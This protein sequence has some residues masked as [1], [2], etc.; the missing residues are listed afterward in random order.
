MY[1]ETKDSLFTAL[2]LRW[3]VI[4]CGVIANQMAEALAAEG[5]HIDG[6]ANRTHEKAVAFANK[7]GVARVYDT[8]DDLIAAPDIDVLYLTTPHNTHITYLR[9]ALAA[10]KHVLCE[11]SI[12]LNSAELAEARELASAHGVQLMDAC[13]ILHMPL[14]KELQR[15]ID[16]GDF[17]QVNLIQENFG[18]YKEYDMKNRFFNPELAGGALLDIGVYSL[19]LARLFLKSQPHEA[20]SMMNPA[21]TGT[22]ETEGILLRNAEGQMVVLSL[23]MHSK[24]PKRAMISADKAY[25]EI[26]EYPRAD[27]A[28]IVWTETGVREELRVGNTAQALSYVLADME[29]AVAG[30]EYARAQLG[31][32]ADVMELMTNLRADWNFKY[33]EEL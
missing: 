11:K 7:H 18:S 8:I 10:G 17:G 24:Q 9:K 16:A 26:M 20:L 6:V 30:D 19:T 21:P 28:S 31:T 32:S 13:T 15:R 2:Q 25:L 3:G 12:T 1:Q 14:Y 5:R 4:G 23:T 29:R 33:P 22:D 27:Q